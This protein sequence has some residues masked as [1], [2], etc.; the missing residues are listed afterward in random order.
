MPSTVVNGEHGGGYHGGHQDK[1]GH[2]SIVFSHDYHGK[3]LNFE[4]PGCNER[5]SLAGWNRSGGCGGP[6]PG[7]LVRGSVAQRHNA[8]SGAKVLW[9]SMPTILMMAHEVHHGEVD[10]AKVFKQIADRLSTKL[11][12]KKR[13]LIRIDDHVPG[14]DGSAKPPKDQISAWQALSGVDPNHK[15]NMPDGW[16]S[17]NNEGTTTI[18]QECWQLGKWDKTTER[19]EFDR[20]ADSYLQLIWVI[21]YYSKTGTY[22]TKFESRVYCGRE[23]DRNANRGFGAYG[24]VAEAFDE[25]QLISVHISK[26]VC[27]VLHASRPDALSQQMMKRFGVDGKPG[28]H[29]TGSF[30]GSAEEEKEIEDSNFEK[31]EKKDSDPNVNPGNTPPPVAPPPGGIGYLTEGDVELDLGT[32]SPAPVQV[33]PIGVVDSGTDLENVLPPVVAKPPVK[34]GDRVPVWQ[35]PKRGAPAKVEVDMVKKR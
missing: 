15:D 25:H 6:D 23:Y 10:R 4:L 21:W 26:E 34:T 1:Y 13:K 32:D 16:S 27:L 18:V 29:K 8:H 28:S 12:G 11:F 7:P 9:V 20:F 17:T 5:A 2:A 30:P 3:E 31:A 22:E 14:I 19:Y 24:V 35:P 33:V